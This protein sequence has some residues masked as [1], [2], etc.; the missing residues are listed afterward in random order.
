M[1]SA[2]ATP[3]VLATRER[4]RRVLDRPAVVWGIRALTFVVLIGTWEV[5]A[6]PINRALWAPPSEVAAAIVTYASQEPTIWEPR[7]RTWRRAGS[8]HL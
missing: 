4:R 3:R 8:A 5:L 1:T 6:A 7:R 2:A